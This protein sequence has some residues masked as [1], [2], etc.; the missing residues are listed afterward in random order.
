MRS[1]EPGTRTLSAG[2]GGVGGCG[3]CGCGCGVVGFVQRAPHPSWVT[4]YSTPLTETRPMRLVG[5]V[6]FV[7]ARTFTV[8]FPAG[9]VGVVLFTTSQSLSL[10]AVHAHPAGAVTVIVQFASIWPTK[11]AV[12]SRRTPHDAVCA[13]A[14]VWLTISAAATASAIRTIF[15]GMEADSGPRRHTSTVCGADLFKID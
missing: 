13:C 14:E 5:A 10:V 7:T 4:A 15:P 11:I 8:P 1:G 9:N 12:L 2:A 6:T 3:C